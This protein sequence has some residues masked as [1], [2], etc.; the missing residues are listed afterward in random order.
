MP[1]ERPGAD[2]TRTRA[3]TNERPA[4]KGRPL[5]LASLMCESWNH[6]GEWQLAVDV[7]HQAGGASR[8]PRPLLLDTLASPHIN[9][10]VRIGQFA[11]LK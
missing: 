7:L 2:E 3:M 8:E 5:E 10:G 1:L 4:E 9:G 6:L 11:I